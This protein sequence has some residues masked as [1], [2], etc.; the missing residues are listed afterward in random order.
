MSSSRSP[1]AAEDRSGQSA[2]RG[3]LFIV[4]APSGTG[5]RIQTN[6]ASGNCIGMVIDDPA[7]RV[8]WNHANDNCSHGIFVMQ[9]GASLL[10]NFANNNAD[11]GIDAPEGTIDLGSNTATGRRGADATAPPRTWGSSWSRSTGILWS[12]CGSSCSRCCTCSEL[13]RRG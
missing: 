10:K 11:F 12:R 3:L 13:W 1:S 2:G 5:I 6:E 8:R 4:S 7:A 9:P